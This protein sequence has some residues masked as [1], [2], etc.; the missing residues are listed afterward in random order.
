MDFR[1]VPRQLWA[2]C[3][4]LFKRL[5]GLEPDSNERLVRQM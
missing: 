4:Y 5:R 1:D 3:V 2:G